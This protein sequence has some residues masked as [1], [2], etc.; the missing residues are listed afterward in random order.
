ML[1]CLFTSSHSC[2]QAYDVDQMVQEVQKTC[3][4]P[5]P[6]YICYLTVFQLQASMTKKRYALLFVFLFCLMGIAE[7]ATATHAAGG[8]L[9]YEW[10]SDSTYRFYFKFYRDC[11]GISE[12]VTIDMCY[13][14]TCSG[15]SYTSVLN[16]V[17]GPL[18]NGG[19]NGQEVSTGCPGYANTCS[20]GAATNPGYREWWYTNL[21]TLPLKC[22]FWKFYIAINARNNNITNLDNP[23]GQTLHIE[24]TLNNLAA[25]GNSSPYFTVKPIPFMCVNTPYTYNNGANDINSDSLVFTMIQPLNSSGLGCQAN[26][27]INSIAWATGTPAYNTTN[28]PLQTNNTFVINP[29][30]GQM[31][32]T[33]SITQTAAI[34]VQVQEYR[35][36]VLIGTV[37]RDIQVVVL[38]CNSPTPIFSQDPGSFTGVQTGANGTLEACALQP[39]TFCSWATSPSTSAVLVASSNNGTVAPGSNVTYTNQATDSVQICFSWTP[40]LADS[41][42]KII[43]FTVKDSTCQP[44]GILLSQTF[45]V[46]IFINPITRAR[47]DTSVCPGG[48]VQM[49]VQGGANFT[50]SVL[51]GGDVNSLSCT[52]CQYPIANPTVTTSYLVVSDLGNNLCQLNSDTVTITVYPSPVFDLG[53]DRIT[54]L[55]GSVQ[56]NSNFTPT[57]GTNYIYSWSPGTYLSA[58]NIPNPVSTPTQDITYTLTITPVGA[59][60]CP[61]T[62][63]V[64]VRVLK[65]FTI[66]NKDSAICKG[67]SVQINAFGPPEYNYT[68]V[69]PV[70]VSNPNVLSPIITPDTTRTYTVTARYPGCPDTSR[71]I[72]FE[73]QPVPQVFAGVDRLLCFADTAQLFALVEPASYPGYSYSWSP[74]GSLDN[75]FVANP[76]FV[77]QVT[78]TLTATVRTP[79]GCTGSDNV[80]MEVVNPD[81]MTISSPDSLL[82]PRDTAQLVVNSA[83]AVS[84]VWTPTTKL[85]DPTSFQ[86]LVWPDATTIYYA[87]GIDNN[88]CKDTA[89]VEVI[90]HPGA[91]LSLADSARIFPGE[92]Y[93]ILPATNC[94][95]FQWF[96]AQ[97]LSS[98]SISNPVAQPETDTRYYIN[99]VTENGCTLTDSID[100]FVSTESLVN[101]P[102]AFLPGANGAANNLTVKVKGIASLKSFTIF[103]RWGTKV[104]ETADINQGWDGTLNGKPQPMGVYIYMVEAVTNSGRP[105]VKQG[106]VTLIR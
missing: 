49:S 33:P 48:T 101:I 21:V 9:I 76:I 75:P 83:T 25:Q 7:K 81:F 69:P 4:L 56:L 11:N 96:P 29:Q 28:N 15:A 3:L 84:V 36:G 5:I 63:Q 88:N 99:A 59:I 37:M 19:V 50:W 65:G 93:Q 34:T 14:S 2:F 45:S 62:D 89:S 70:G 77:A 31:N 104:F 102:N 98:T 86:T 64:N 16:K 52:N 24:A 73:V 97:G 53:A 22:N 20:G 41:G 35:N 26:P 90:V 46:P 54:C 44:P 82:C 42:L 30:T 79:A 13:Y 47:T 10:V 87:V 58:T 40:Q 32:F 105:F 106:N 78:S 71:S 17:T 18:P 95:Y 38:N 23:G 61:S 1:L 55:G 60:S 67:A 57:P 85:S 72:T 91:T 103:N 12:P 8:E 43:T 66:F 51:P 39:L 80:K 100:V 68:W 74:T 92:S 94:A 27:P 6:D